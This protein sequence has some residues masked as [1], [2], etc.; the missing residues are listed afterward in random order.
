MYAP[1]V[2][3]DHR[4]VRA[5]LSLHIVPQHHRHSKQVRLAFIIARLL[6]NRY[7]LEFQTCLDD[8]LDD[9][10]QLTVT[11]EDKWNQFKETVTETATSVLGPKK[12]VHQDWFDENDE[13]IHALLDEKRKAFID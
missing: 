12:R 11:P 7:H 9:R 8:N 3:T 10:G 6:S 1:A 4:H 13:A 5:K 2:Q